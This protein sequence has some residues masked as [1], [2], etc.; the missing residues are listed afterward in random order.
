MAW[1]CM[2]NRHNI[3]HKCITVC[4]SD[5]EAICLILFVIVRA[6]HKH[7]NEEA[8]RS[9]QIN[10]ASKA[11]LTSNLLYGDPSAWWSRH[12]AGIFIWTT[13]RMPST[14]WYVATPLTAQQFYL[15]NWQCW[16]CIHQLS[17]GF[18]SLVWAFI[19][20]S[21]QHTNSSELTTPN[22]H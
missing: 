2:V 3:Q 20:L 22:P 8:F 11:S 6:W 9:I 17:T 14:I 18:V 12:F 1:R 16:V 10:Q 19:C 13:Y 15:S 21:Q 5:H 4:A 7:R